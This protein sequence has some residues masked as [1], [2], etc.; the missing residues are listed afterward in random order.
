M[1][2]FDNIIVMF[3]L[4]NGVSVEIM[5]CY[6]G[7]DLEVV[8]GSVVSYFCLGLGF[9]SVVNMLYWRYKIWVYEGG[10]SMLFF[11]CWLVGLLVW[12]EKWIIFVYVVDIVFIV[13]DLFNLVLKGLFEGNVYFFFFGWSFV[14]VFVEDFW[15]ECDELW[16]LYEGYWVIWV[17]D[18]KFVVVKD[19][20][21]ELY[22]FMNDCV[23]VNDVVFDYFD[24]VEEFVSCWE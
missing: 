24:L 18:W 3:V 14:L 7:Y 17:D 23:E 13:F 8:F 9:L 21:W 1:G 22:D 16:W 10:I 4:D 11:I 19:M 2:V 15:V 20:L 6:G 5:V 12:G